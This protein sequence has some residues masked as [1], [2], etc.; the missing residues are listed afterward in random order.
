[1]L[2]FFEAFNLNKLIIRNKN[3]IDFV[4][5]NSVIYIK[6]ESGYCEIHTA[7]QKYVDCKSLKEYQ[8]KLMLANF[9]RVSQ[10]HLINMRHIAKFIKGNGGSIIMD[11]GE[12]ISLS[13][14]CRKKFLT[15]I[16]YNE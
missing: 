16:K 14:S 13:R 2:D 12:T 9:F 11:N 10:S 3:T 6:G 7:D 5:I 4:D 1:M 8:E 15:R